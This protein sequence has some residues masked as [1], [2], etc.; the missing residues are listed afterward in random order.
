MKPLNCLPL[1]LLTVFMAVPV[2]LKAQKTGT[3]AGKQ[4]SG[5]AGDGG[6]ATAALLCRATCVVTDK[7]GNLYL[8][9]FRNHVVRKIDKKGIITTIAGNH[10]MGYSGDGGPA[11]AAQLKYPWGIATDTEGNLYIADKEN[12]AIRKV[13]SQGII[14][15]VAGKGTAGYSADNGAATAAQ[16]NHPLGIATDN[17][18]CIYIAD[19][20]NNIIR[21]VNKAGIISTIAGNRTRGYSG[22]GGGA[23]AAALNNPRYVAVDGEG[24]VF[25]SDTWNSVIRKVTTDGLIHT[26]AGNHKNEYSGDGGQATAAGLYYPVGI[27]I[28]ADQCLYI[29]DNHNH[30]IRKIDN[31]GIITTVAGNGTK[32]YSGNGAPATVAQIA[33]PTSVAIDEQ[34]KLYIAEFV[35]N[36][37]RV[38]SLPAFEGNEILNIYPNPNRGTFTL[39]LPPAK[40]VTYTTISDMTGQQI[41][42]RTIAPGATKTLFTLGDIAPGTYM[43]H[44]ASGDKKYD[45]KVVVVR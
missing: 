18:G 9:D 45:R 22:N 3:F 20:A 43:M 12:H 19:N 26:V 7:A 25:I 2:I 1:L 31:T 28:A 40:A 27:A 37:V 35:N 42:S 44:I 11:T 10:K 36:L 39:E 38:V 5:Y 33:H 32:G 8:T 17:E 16:L 6:P 30:A 29:A 24:N 4:Q 15:T 41:D 14:S 21:K 23:T 13:N 34:G